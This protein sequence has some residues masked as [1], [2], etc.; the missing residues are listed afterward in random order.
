MHD[1]HKKTLYDLEV[2]GKK[3]SCGVDGALTPFS[4]LPSSARCMLRIGFKHQQSTQDRDAYPARNNIMQVRD[5]RKLEQG[6]N[7]V[8]E[9][10]SH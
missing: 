5:E 7:A 2:D 10:A 9:A 6:V 3:H 4:I 8:V 1:L